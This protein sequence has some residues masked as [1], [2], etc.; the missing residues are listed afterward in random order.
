MIFEGIEVSQKT[1]DAI[2]HTYQIDGRSYP[3][4]TVELYGREGSSVAVDAPELHK[5]AKAALEQ[6]I[7]EAKSLES[8]QPFK[9]KHSSFDAYLEDLRPIHQDAAEKRAI[10]KTRY[11]TEVMLWTEHGR[12]AQSDLERERAKVH[13]EDAKK[14]YAD[15]LK[16]LQDET[17][18]AV[19]A[20][21][22]ALNGHLS[23]FYRADGK[24]INDD[25]LKLLKSGLRLT[26]GEINSLA[27]KHSGNPAMLRL[28]GQYCDDNRIENTL[29]KT[30]SKRALSNGEH[31]RS[32]FDHVAQKLRYVV[33]SDEMSARINSKHFERI[34]NEQITGLQN[35]MVKP[36]HIDAE[37]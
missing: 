35:V 17:E 25:D 36:S 8:G 37:S 13:L 9:A 26:E 33:G 20:I 28:I 2:N 3:L 11:D 14:E 12:T 21:R 5:A 4:K 15:G 31:E 10:L 32:A 24:N 7:A 30:L 22:T 34:L 23:D 19:N 27:N 18:A 6:I 16:A 1:Y 29:A